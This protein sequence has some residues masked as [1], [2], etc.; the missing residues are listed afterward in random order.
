MK[1]SVNDFTPAEGAAN[2]AAPFDPKYKTPV[3]AQDPAVYV[4]PT[5]TLADNPQQQPA[6][7]APGLTLNGGSLEIPTQTRTQAP[8]TPAAMQFGNLTIPIQKRR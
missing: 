5:V 3:P 4:A 7:V 2:G 8:A 1:T 6:I